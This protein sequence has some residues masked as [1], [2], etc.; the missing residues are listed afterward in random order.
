MLFTSGRLGSEYICR[1]ASLTKQSKNLDR[2]DTFYIKSIEFAD[3]AEFKWMK[4]L[5][6]MSRCLE[7]NIKVDYSK[8]KNEK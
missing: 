7:E 8:S 1:V 3:Y 2:N 6:Y 4:K 5:G